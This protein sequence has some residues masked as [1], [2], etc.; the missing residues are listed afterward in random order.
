MELVAPAGNTEKLRYAYDFGADAVY[1]GLKDFSLR[2]QA[3]NFSGA[4]YQEFAA[5]KKNKKLY[6]ALNI[7]F[8]DQDIDRLRRRLDEIACFPFDGFI[9]SDLGIVRLLQA[10]FPDVPLHLSTQANCI[11]ADAAAMYKDLGFSRL[12]PGRELSLRQIEH[13]KNRV[14]IKIE[15]FAH[16]AMCLAY[17]GRCFLSSYMSG[18]SA[19]KGDCAHSCR[20]RFRVLEEEER[21]GEYFPV[22]EGKDFTSIL[23]SRDLCMVGHLADLRDAGVDAVKIEGRMKSIYYTAVVTRAY[24]KAL[25]KLLGRT[26]EDIDPYIAELS[27]VSHRE[28]WTGFYLDKQE[29]QKPT[30]K[31]YTRSHAFLGT[32]GPE[33]GPGTFRLRVK[34]QVRADD[35]IEYIG[36]DICFLEDTGFTLLDENMRPVEKADHGKEYY[37]RTCQKV[38]PG[39]IVRKKLS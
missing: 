37:L 18:R 27:K 26:R 36:P 1:I 14:D 23:S 12:V 24:R 19:N 8:H 3:D 17:A 39:Y 21:P 6:G 25:D 7:Y 38:N 33:T 11:N 2:A 31:S 15:V 13:I 30:L 16:G 9:V 28:F 34:N 32:V 22:I 29:I 5:I 20:W 4:F 10:R 35:I